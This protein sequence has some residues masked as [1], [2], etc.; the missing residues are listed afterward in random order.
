M[1]MNKE[2]QIEEIAKEIEK[3]Y[4]AYKGFCPRKLNRCG[5]IRNC[6]YCNIATN[7]IE[8]GYRKINENEVV[9]SKEEYELL[10]KNKGIEHIQE[11]AT[12]NGKLCLVKDKMV[13]KEYPP[14][15]VNFIRKE[16]AREI[17]GALYLLTQQNACGIALIAKES[18]EDLAK[19]YGVEIGEEK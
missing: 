14:D 8:Q 11:F 16:T 7:L 4:T 6:I 10:I 19:K 3:S 12:I 9:I 1:E 17:L 13:L 18:V 5:T 15:A 2:K